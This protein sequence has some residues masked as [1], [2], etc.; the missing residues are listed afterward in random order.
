MYNVA[1]VQPQLIDLQEE[2]A[3][4]EK[5]T[6]SAREEQILGLAASG[7]LDKEIV[8]EL[9]VSIHTLHT[10]WKRIRAK[11]GEGN[12]SALVAEYV[13]SQSQ[14]LRTTNPSLTQDPDAVTVY[15]ATEL[16]RAQASEQKSQ[17]A[18]NVL[19]SIFTE[20]SK[21]TTEMQLFEVTCKLLAETGGYQLAWIGVPI[22]DEDKS[23]VQIARHPADMY[24]E[25][26]VPVSWG[27]GPRGQGPSGRAVRSGKVEVSRDFLFDPKMRPWLV[28]AQEL[29]FQSS[30]ALPIIVRDHVELVISVFAPEPDAFDHHEMELLGE[31][32]QVFAIR[33][34]Q[35]REIPLAGGEPASWEMDLS[36][37]TIRN[38]DISMC[39]KLN[40]EPGVKIDLERVFPFYHPADGER[41]RQ[42]LIAARDTHVP[43]FTYRARLGPL[44]GL[45][46]AMSYV[47][48]IRDDV[49]KTTILR[50]RR[51]VAVDLTAEP[52]GHSAIGHYSEDLRTGESK[53][54]SDC[55]RILGISEF[56]TNIPTAVR[57]R[58]SA[59]SHVT[60]DDNVADVIGD[61]R[62]KVCWAVPLLDT[63]KKVRWVPVETRVKYE[64]GIPAS[65]DLVFLAYS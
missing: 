63:K 51:V 7:L 50:G 39:R 3:R 5:A 26:Y 18:M 16:R 11:L 24:E 37:W 20:S 35:L 64:D 54:D 30:L 22:N 12:R 6:L 9:G 59:S 27:D 52:F 38:F 49:K 65:F 41:V 47:E 29:G 43:S 48:V 17:R 31:V 62:T 21:V 33:L 13:R 2:S 28:R 19:R 60:L 61:R 58:I 36:D 55:R 34:A 44:S 53:I 40:A 8:R 57:S 56:E 14:K 23:V 4:S 15:L 45:M 10:Y 25:N 32:A 1:T 42:L 46:M